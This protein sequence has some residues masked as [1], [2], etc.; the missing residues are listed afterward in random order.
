MGQWSVPW[1]LGPWLM[2]CSL[3]QA[4]QY[5]FLANCSWSPDFRWTLDIPS[6]PEPHGHLYL[7]T[8]GEAI[9]SPGTGEHFCHCSLP[10]GE[11]WTEIQGTFRVDGR[12][13]LS[14][15][16]KSMY[17]SLP[18]DTDITHR[19]IHEDDSGEPSSTTDV[20]TEHFWLKVANPWD[21]VCLGLWT[22]TSCPCLVSYIF[23]LL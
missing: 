18:Q 3:V 15:G 6:L 10:R 17:A 12:R 8:S 4:L 23:V 16:G 11:L 19:Y 21:P 22:M 7:H 5:G 9:R 20:L 14:R 2:Q 13:T 1:G